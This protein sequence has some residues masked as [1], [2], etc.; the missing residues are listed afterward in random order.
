VFAAFFA[1]SFRGCVVASRRSTR[2]AH[3]APARERA[4][5]VG[6]SQMTVQRSTI[7]YSTTVSAPKAL[8]ELE[9]RRLGKED[10]TGGP[11]VPGRFFDLAPRLLARIGHS[12]W[13]MAATDNFK[14]TRMLRFRASIERLKSSVS[15]P[16]EGSEMPKLRGFLTAIRVSATPVRS[17]NL[18]A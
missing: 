16:Q 15:R 7:V 5:S 18:R 8:D 1:S 9:R 17:C 2:R 11:R 14:M 4:G 13:R 12:R 10:P 6:Y 3:G